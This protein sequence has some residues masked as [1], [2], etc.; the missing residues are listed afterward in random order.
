MKKNYFHSPLLLLI[1]LVVFALPI[2]WG[3]VAIADIGQP[4]IFVISQ[5]SAKTVLGTAIEDNEASSTVSLP[6]LFDKEFNG[7]DLQLGRVL[8]NNSS[9]T[10]YYI[11]YKSGNLTIS[12]IM[13]VPKG[14]GPFPAL[15]LN[16]GHIDTSVYTNGRGLRREQDYLARAGYVVLHPDY[17]NHADSSQDNRDALAVRLGYVE[18]VINAVYA[19]KNSSLDYIDT[20]NIGMLGHSMGGGITLSVLVSQP[21]L[22]KAAVLYAPVSGDMRQSYERWI[23]RQSNNIEEIT[24]TYG[25]PDEAP[26]FW[27]NISAETFYDRLTAPVRIFHGTADASVPLDWSRETLSRLQAAG[28]KVELTV[29][30]GAPHEFTSHWSSFMQSAKEFFDSRLK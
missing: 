26:E 3:F 27:D 12:G 1:Y 24:G 7:A 28:A 5:P 19:L 9:Y 15:V 10:R 14:D 23:A 17:R 20:V 13:N 25:S 29:Y 16:H 8:E 2:T 30:D 11:T 18:D 21:D 4:E 6:A 22:V